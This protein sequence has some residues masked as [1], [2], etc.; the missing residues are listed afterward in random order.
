[1]SVYNGERFLREAVDS[2]LA[3]TMPN[4]EF[5]VIDDGSTDRSSEIL[6]SYR[7]PRLIVVHQE[8]AGLAAALNRGLLMARAKIVARMDSDDIALPDRLEVQL[9][10]Y[11]R[12]GAPDVLGGHVEYISENGHF[13]GSRRQPLEH[14]DIV[15]RL[16]KRRGGTPIIHPTVFLKSSSVLSHGGYDEFFRYAS[17]DYD[18]WL[19]MLHDC[20]F[21][22]TERVVLRYRLNSNSMESRITKMSF[23]TRTSGSWWGCVARQRYFLEKEGAGNLWDDEAARERILEMLW[24]R[25]IK[26]G[27]HKSRFVNRSLA[28][29]HADLKTPGRKFAALSSALS[30]CF[31]KPFVTARYLLLRRQNQPRYLSAGEI[32]ISLGSEKIML[33]K[34]ITL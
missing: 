17:E 30:L 2:I 23:P 19:R 7:D 21:A 5:I 6:N 20:R 22:N 12:L 29:I 9:A 18:L 1:M 26:S 32:A 34:K 10:E 33:D 4:F 28:L 27:L 3:Q 24:P 31:S 25:F 16:V 13:L 15:E 14:W 8:N 11:K